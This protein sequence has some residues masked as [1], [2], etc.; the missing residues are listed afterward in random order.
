MKKI[1]TLIACSAFVSTMAFSQ[2]IGYKIDKNYVVYMTNDSLTAYTQGSLDEGGDGDDFADD[3]QLNQAFS[4]VGFPYTMGGNG[5][6]NLQCLTKEYT[7]SETGAFFPAGYYHVHRT[8]SQEKFT[9]AIHSGLTHCKKI[10]FYYG[11]GGQGQFSATMR[12]S[13]DKGDGTFSLVTLT[14]DPNRK[15]SNYQC[16]GVSWGTATNFSAENY[17]KKADGVTD[18]LATDGSHLFKAN[19]ATL[20]SFDKIFKL[21]IDYTNASGTETETTTSDYTRKAN[22]DDN[23]EFTFKY[24]FTP[25]ADKTYSGYNPENILAVGYKKAGY[26][27]G[28]A[29][30]SNDNNAETVYMNVSDGMGASWSKDNAGAFGTLFNEKAAPDYYEKYNYFFSDRYYG[31]EIPALGGVG[32]NDIKTDAN[33]TIEAIYNVYGIKFETLQDGINIV[34]YSDG[35]VSKVYK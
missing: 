3:N 1:F 23:S 28:V 22:A 25:A 31:N 6:A 26:L 5:N 30:I 4:T 29:F 14:N 15:L 8:N 11:V 17:L 12:K 35:S 32:I 13:E 2:Q 20:Q 24:N 33:V 7:D 18:S 19:E 16:D 27:L 21:T 34:K 10:I 9:N